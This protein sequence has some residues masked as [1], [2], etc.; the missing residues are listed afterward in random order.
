M[1]TAVLTVS[2]SAAFGALFLL[3]AAPKLRRPRS[4]L[5]TVMEYQVMPE[6]AARLSARLIPSTELLVAL[7]LLSGVALRLAALLAAVLLLGFAAGVGI[8][9]SRGRHLDCGCFG[10][11]S[12]P[13]SAALLIQDLGLVSFAIL[14][15]SLSGGW[16]GVAWWSIFR[17]TNFSFGFITCLCM[18][19][20]TAMVA[21]R[22]TQ[23]FKRQT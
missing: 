23:R 9:L 20:L 3:S 16:G 8:N 7:L 14:L 2:L 6:G 18:A 15:V 1:F 11:H 17:F 4:F 22:P 5:L 10:K 12:R 21:A 13:I 19:I